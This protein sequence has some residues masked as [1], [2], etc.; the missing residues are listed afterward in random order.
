LAPLLR[1]LDARDGA[2][3]D[4]WLGNDLFSGD[5][6][7]LPG[8][9]AFVEFQAEVLERLLRREPIGRDGVTD[10]LF[11]E[12]KSTDYAG[13]I[14][15]MLKPEVR[16]VVEAQDRML[17][18]LVAGLDAT[19]GPRRWVLAVTAD[20]GQTPI[21][22][23]T[24]GLR[25][26][27]V[28]LEADVEEYFG[29]DIVEAVHPTEMYLDRDALAEAGITVAD[30]ARFVGAYRYRDGL[31]EGADPQGISRE[32]LDRRVFAGALPGSLLLGLTAADL[33]ALGPGAY[34]EGDLSSRTG[35]GSLL[36]R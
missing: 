18:E 33:A 20:H 26:D 27:R 21:P 5:T 14:W 7:I 28:Q 36:T 34:P 35:Y 16:E 4:R 9:P 17:A 8:T 3:D 15:N 23:T 11:V 25:I 30:V 19:V 31:P 22:T 13:H 32:L 29:A 12:M 1:E 2:R 6:F 24:G 10:F